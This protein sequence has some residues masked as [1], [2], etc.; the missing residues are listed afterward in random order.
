M[1][2][3][4]YA[5]LI[6]VFLSA[7]S[8]FADNRVPDRAGRFEI[9][10]TVLNTT[11]NYSEQAWAP[12][13]RALEQ[14][15]EALKRSRREAEELIEKAS[16]ADNVVG[17][18]NR[19]PVAGVV[20]TLRLGALTT[21]TLTDSEGRFYF[22][23]LPQGNYELEAR[24]TLAP[25]LGQGPKRMLI[26]KKDLQIDQYGRISYPNNPIQWGTPDFEFRADTV[27]VRGRILNGNGQPIAGAKV[28]GKQI[29]PYNPELG[30]P[31]EEYV[32]P[33]DQAVSAED[34]SYMLQGFKPA[35][36]RNV[37]A[38]LGGISSDTLDRIEIHAEVGGKPEVL[39]VP[40]VTEDLIAPARRH[41]KLINKYS[42]LAEPSRKER[43]REKEGVFLPA[44]LGNVI[45]VVDMRLSF[46]K[47][48]KL[49]G[50]VVDDAS[51]S[52][53]RDFTIQAS[54][55][56]SDHY[57]PV[58][59]QASI[60]KSNPGVFWVSD[61]FPATWSLDVSA[62]GY[63][64][65]E[66]KVEIQ[67]EK[68]SQAAFRLERP[69][70]ISGLVLDTGSGAPVSQ[71]TVKVIDI[72]ATGDSRQD[73]GRVALDESKKGV[74]TIEGIC[75]ST[76]TLMIESS[77]YAREKALVQVGNGEKIEKTFQLDKESSLH[78]EI[79]MNGKPKDGQVGV[80]H[81][82]QEMEEWGYLRSKD[83]RYECKYLKEGEYTVGVSFHNEGAHATTWL[84][85]RKKIHIGNGQES[86]LD[87]HLQG[88][89]GIR[90]VFNGPPALA[91]KLNYQ[92]GEF[93]S[94]LLVLDNGLDPSLPE[95][96]R[97]RANAY[98]MERYEGAYAISNLPAGS[99]TVIGMIKRTADGKTIPEMQQEKTVVLKEGEVAAVNFTFR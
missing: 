18:I 43:W 72:D 10:G 34:G 91:D 51:G 28:T 9:I 48:G 87:F 32:A 26:Q 55:K 79:T 15:P 76:V 78:G 92:F 89:A 93:Y 27:T 46:E 36:I 70:K 42:S 5:G 23:G 94:Y 98:K 50:Q 53:V 4:R 88:T 61:L 7:A 85:H 74:F 1:S 37:M 65:Q 80:H 11:P 82:G 77:G 41:G 58:Q 62:P 59:R 90:G 2:A 49:S 33:N 86:R 20:V 14:Y 21:Q 39:S 64:P 25:P 6:L 75:P 19:I 56:F 35:G 38:Y 17:R 83:G 22:S 3:G 16:T 12:L 69:G 13:D 54:Y 63:L 96:E 44:S 73:P 68:T 71:F 99:Y 40:L 24:M 97:T 8:A 84:M 67:S 47:A 29:H 60:D 45:T 95:G 81:T 66:T 57:L 52:P 30:Q 31:P